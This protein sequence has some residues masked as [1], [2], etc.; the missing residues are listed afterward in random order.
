MIDTMVFDA[1]V[2]D[3]E[4]H[5]GALAAVA[6][7]RLRLV[8]TPL[9]EEQVAAI[10]DARRRKALQALP[11]EVVPPAPRPTIAEPRAKHA[12]DAL[13]ADTARE[14]CDVLV[15]EDGRLTERAR[16]SGLEVWD[17]ARLR[18]W[19]AGDAAR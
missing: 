2:D 9:Q 12:A 11:R 16:A 14:R 4:L 18:R 3:P 7:R 19:L 6:E 10:G 8:T 15:T 1:T 13:I 17:V 5:A